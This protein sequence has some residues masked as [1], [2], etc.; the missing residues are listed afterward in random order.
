MGSVPLQVRLATWYPEG[1][2]IRPEAA[3]AFLAPGTQ[4]TVRLS[5]ALTDA[6]QSA[7][8]DLVVD[9]ESERRHHSLLLRGVLSV[10]PKPIYFRTY[11]IIAAVGAF[12]LA[13]RTVLQFRYR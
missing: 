3:E 9:A 7:D 8:Y 2:S 11:L 6:G 4:K 13:V 1:F 10:V 12:L 5:A